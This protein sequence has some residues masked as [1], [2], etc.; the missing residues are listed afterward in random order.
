MISDDF[1]RCDRAVKPCKNQYVSILFHMRVVYSV[2]ETHTAEYLRST[3]HTSNRFENKSSL[4]IAARPRTRR[5]NLLFSEH[6]QLFSLQLFV[7][8]TCLMLLGHRNI[9]VNQI[10]EATFATTSKNRRKDFEEPFDATDT[11]ANLLMATLI[12]SETVRSSRRS[13][14]IEQAL[15]SFLYPIGRKFCLICV[16]IR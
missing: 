4:Y 8:P 16:G 11:H 1:R 15:E 3:G 14:Q 6:N 12:R 5:Q 2:T 9:T 13:N 7:K 10:E